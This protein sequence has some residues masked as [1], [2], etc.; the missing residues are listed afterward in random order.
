MRALM[1]QNSLDKMKVFD[2]RQAKVP[3][4]K[5]KYMD[6]LNLDISLGIITNDKVNAAA[7]I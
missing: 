2:V 3:I 5:V 1:K 7:S 6:Q 4:L